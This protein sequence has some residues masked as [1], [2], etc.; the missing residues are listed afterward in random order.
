MS[1]I[2]KFV[3]K[4]VRSRPKYDHE[5]HRLQIRKYITV[6]EEK[7]REGVVASLCFIMLLVKYSYISTVASSNI[8]FSSSSLPSHILSTYISS[9]ATTQGDNYFS[10]FS[11]WGYL[12]PQ[13][14]QW[15]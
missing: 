11:I 3:S 12:A 5:A 4:T 6:G 14:A 9:L 10:I 8:Q 13:K 2:F 1:V 7:V 15:C